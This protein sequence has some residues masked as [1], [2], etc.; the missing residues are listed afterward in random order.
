MNLSIHVDWKVYLIASSKSQNY[1]VI[2]VERDL[3]IHLVQHHSITDTAGDE[4]TWFLE[5]SKKETP[6]ALWKH[7]SEIC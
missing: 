1:R 6:Q 2:E 5:I 4:A 3:W 7:A